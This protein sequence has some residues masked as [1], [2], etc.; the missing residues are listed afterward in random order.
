VAHARLDHRWEVAVTL[1]TGKAFAHVSFVNNIATSRGGTHVT[2]VADLT[3]KALVQLIGSARG[4]SKSA[5]ELTAAD[6]R[7]H[8]MLFVN[9]LVVNPTFDTQTKTH[10][11]TKRA[12]LDQCIA[13]GASAA[14]AADVRKVPLA[15]LDTW[16]KF[17]ATTLKK[18]GLVEAIIERATEKA[19]KK[20]AKTDG[21]AGGAGKRLTGIAKLEDA[22]DAG[23]KNG[24]LCTL[25][26]TEGP[27]A[28]HT[29][30]TGLRGATV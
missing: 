2:Y 21:K 27:S 8:L 9:A 30:M 11:T 10:L 15:A 20:L 18:S 23:T 13:A 28:Q 12:D 25:I 17:V 22:N 14:A 19:D 4:A 29:C 1:S 26:L 6:V 3:C 16:T 24:H 7:P 5:K